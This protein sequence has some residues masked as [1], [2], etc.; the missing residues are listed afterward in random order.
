MISSSD[1]NL[2]IEIGHLKHVFVKINKYPH[3]V[4]ENTFK[5]IK[6]KISSECPAILG[7]DENV[8]S[9]D[10]GSSVDT[11]DDITHPHIILPYKG[12]KGDKLVKRLKKLLTSILPK[13]VVPRM[14]Y[15]G[16]KL[17]SFFPI[18]DKV[19]SIHSSDL[20]YGYHVP[21]KETESYHY[22]GE[23]SVRHETRVYQHGYTDK[24]SAI[25]KHSHEHDYVAAPSNF[26]IL[27]SGY[28]KW[29]DRKLCEALFVRDH[30]PFLNIQKN[31]HKLE[32]FT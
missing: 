7:V 23:T 4:V 14:V 3:T 10:A 9:V 19:S 18:K 15:Q 30:K 20:V 31:S 12:F 8:V 21:G 13:N 5:F 11:S 1:E 25:Y 6:S 16:K 17:A 27:A 26:S 2:D 29:F 24:K 32:L 22:I 28:H